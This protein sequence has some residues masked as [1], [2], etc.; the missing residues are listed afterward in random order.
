MKLESID[1]APKDGTVIEATHNREPGGEFRP[2]YRTFWG[3]GKPHTVE[4]D[5]GTPIRG[6]VVNSGKPW[7]LS[8]GGEK[9]APTPTHWKPDDD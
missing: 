9:L 7:W 6:Y 5:D 3:V 4:S 2:L 1:T 8:E